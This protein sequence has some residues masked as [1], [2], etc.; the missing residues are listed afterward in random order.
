MEL[1]ISIAIAVALAEATFG[2]Q[3]LRNASLSMPFLNSKA[4]T[5]R[6]AA[7]NGKLP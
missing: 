1:A 5:K 6:V 3:R 7:R 2:F 4:T